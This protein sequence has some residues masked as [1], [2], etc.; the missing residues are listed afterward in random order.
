MQVRCIDCGWSIHRLPC[1]CGARRMNTGLQPKTPKPMNNSDMAAG[2]FGLVFI[3]FCLV[4]ALLMVVSLWM[5]FSK[6]GQP[7]WAAIIPILNLYFLV[8]V[9]GRP[10]WWI[11]LYLIPIVSI[12]ISILVS[13]D[14]AKNFGKGGGF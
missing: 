14:V 8:K 4:F 7:G 13:L 1:L 6:A 12:I 9:S 10:G 2:A 11:L 3:L 5:V